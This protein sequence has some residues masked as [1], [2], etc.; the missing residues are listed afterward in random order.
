M[1]TFN[2]QAASVHCVDA[3]SCYGCSM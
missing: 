3:A 2:I 1:K